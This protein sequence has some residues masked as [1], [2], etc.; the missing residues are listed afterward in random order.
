MLSARPET[1]EIDFLENT[2]PSG[3]VEIVF[4]EAVIA[5]LGSTP[6]LYG[7]SQTT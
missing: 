1:R 3:T 5:R 4:D 2:K 7:C 6:I